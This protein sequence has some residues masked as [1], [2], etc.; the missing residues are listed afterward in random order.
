MSLKF[1]SITFSSS[2]T[3]IHL[4]PS[5]A[6]LFT[7]NSPLE[8]TDARTS[9]ASDYRNRKNK[10]KKFVVIAFNGSTENES[11]RFILRFQP[12]VK[13][14]Q[15][16]FNNYRVSPFLCLQFSRQHSTALFIERDLR[17]YD[18]W[19]SWY[20]RQ[21]DKSATHEWPPKPSPDLFYA[22][23]KK[24][25]EKDWT[26]FSLTTVKIRFDFKKSSLFMNKFPDREK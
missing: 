15:T 13:E 3:V 22:N 23:F 20:A 19:H 1:S 18:R 12:V 10:R 11:L 9:S 5:W 2:W 16:M 6:M 17:S 8:S 14:M 25:S 7:F 26:S 4:E 21:T 24:Y